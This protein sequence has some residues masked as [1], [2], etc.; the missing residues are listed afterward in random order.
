VEATRVWSLS[1]ISARQH[2][3]RIVAIVFYLMD[4]KVQ[5]RDTDRRGRTK[6]FSVIS[7]RPNI[8]VVYPARNMTVP[9]Q[10]EVHD[11]SHPGISMHGIMSRNAVLMFQR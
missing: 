9:V 11:R 4:D 7:S 8:V 5:S 3:D 1:R 2:E 10:V 6:M